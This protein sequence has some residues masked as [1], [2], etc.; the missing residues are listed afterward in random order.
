VASGLVDERYA[1]IGYVPRSEPAR[2]ALWAE[3]AAWRWPAV[4][5]ESPKR[6]PGT[7]A[8]LARADPV[9]SVAVCRELTKRF[10]EV[11]R[12][13]APELLRRFTEAPKGEI[14]LVIGAPASVSQ[15]EAEV[16]TAAMAVAELVAAGAA[17]RQAARVVARL[18]GLPANRLYD[19][20]L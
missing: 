19:R 11:A 2:T 17:R 20:S 3:L 12:G 10:E 16:E 14:T 13:T 15:G 7:L 9:R 5:F 6:L 18:V 4:A 8:S 1:F